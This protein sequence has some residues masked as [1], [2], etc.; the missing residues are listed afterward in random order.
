MRV[1]TSL[2]MNNNQVLF[3]C[4]G[5]YYRSRFA[6]ELFNFHAERLGLRWLAASK[7]F[8]PNPEQNPGTISPH[9]LRGLANLNIH[10][11]NANRMPVSLSE[12]DFNQ[13]PRI[14]AMSDS[15]HRPMLNERFPGQESFVEFWTAED[16]HLESPIE[17]LPKIITSLDRLIIE[18]GGD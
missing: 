3:I 10:P 18:L 5:N 12:A 9:A 8:R 2:Q 1:A 6:E 14:I 16:L 4:T 17:A 11:K 7:G 15:E 13:F